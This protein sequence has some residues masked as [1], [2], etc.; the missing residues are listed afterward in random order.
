[1]VEHVVMWRIKDLDEGYDTKSAAWKMKE[2]L[3]S[4]IG[5]IPGLTS[6]Q[7]GINENQ[8]PAAYHICLITEHPSWNDLKAY[9]EN[10]VHKEVAAFVT[11]IS[12]ERAI[13]DF[14]YK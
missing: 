5:K 10:P 9:Q 4:M 2:K 8:S 11:E 13:V 3:E 1:M 6:L 14:E 12:K 7:V